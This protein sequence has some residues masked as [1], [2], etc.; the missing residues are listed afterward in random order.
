MDKKGHK[1]AIVL[2]ESNK[3][4]ENI[5]ATNSLSESK[6][7]INDWQTQEAPDIEM[8]IGYTV[9]YKHEKMKSFK[10]LNFVQSF[11]L[12]IKVLTSIL[13]TMERYSSK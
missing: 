5:S 1:K 3:D 2:K 8:D 13:S 6:S 12:Y 11:K 10:I 4:D 9:K 7:D